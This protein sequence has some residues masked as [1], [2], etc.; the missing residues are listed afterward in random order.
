M[1]ATEELSDLLRRFQ[2]M[3]ATG[4]FRVNPQIASADWAAPPQLSRSA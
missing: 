3:R 2:Q 1:V 4:K